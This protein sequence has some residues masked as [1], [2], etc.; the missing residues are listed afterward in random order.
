MALVKC[1]ECGKQVSDQAK[2]C[3]HCGCPIEKKQFCP[4]CGKEVSD[5]A[6]VCPTCG[7]PINNTSLPEPQ[8]VT[9]TS[10]STSPITKEKMNGMALAGGITALCSLIIDLVGIVSIVAIVLSCVGLGEVNRTGQRGKGW[11]I[12]GIVVGSIE[13]LFKVVTL[14]PYL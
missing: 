9:S 4:E 6:T 8:T 2:V 1:S 14:F 10:V 13:L 11:A 12:T 3:V 5:K 7:C